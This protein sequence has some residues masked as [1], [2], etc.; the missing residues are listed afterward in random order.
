MSQRVHTTDR[1]T[2]H[3]ATAYRGGLF[4]VVLNVGQPVKEF[5]PLEVLRGDCPVGRGAIRIVEG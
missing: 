2:Q 4:R 5:A 1:D 3:N